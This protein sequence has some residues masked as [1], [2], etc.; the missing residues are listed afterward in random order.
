[1][2][3]IVS[4]YTSQVINHKCFVPVREHPESFIE[5]LQSSHQSCARSNSSRS[6]RSRA[7]SLEVNL[8][9]RSV[10][11]TSFSNLEKN[12]DRTSMEYS[13]MYL[14]REES[15]TAPTVTTRFL[16][17]LAELFWKCSTGCQELPTK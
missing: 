4:S 15:R 9:V 6:A 11:T 7:S 10:N 2:G 3:E 12:I 17:W 5:K 14:S 13:A 1:M 8:S 16:D